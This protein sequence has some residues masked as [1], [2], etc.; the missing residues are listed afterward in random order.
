MDGIN[1]AEAQRVAQAAVEHLRSRRSQSLMVVAMN[2]QQKERIESH[3]ARLEAGNGGLGAILDESE[4]E[5]RIEP[6]VVKNL[7][8]VQG[9]E[10]DVVMISMTYGPRE[11]GG[12]VPQTFGPINQDKGHRRLNVLFTRAK[13]QMVVFTSLRSTDIQAGPESNP[14]PRALQGFLRFAETKQL[15]SGSRLTGKSPES[16]F[17]EAVARELERAGYGVEPQLGVGSYRIDIAVRNPDAPDQFLLGVE[18]DG[19]MYHTTLSAR[20]RDRLRQEVLENL[21]WEIERI[22]SVDWFRDPGRELKRVLDRLRELRQPPHPSTEGEAEERA[23]QV[24]DETAAL[25]GDA[26]RVSKE[27]PKPT[28]QM[29]GLPRELR[30]ALASARQSALLIPAKRALT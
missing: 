2:I 5:A 4:A 19:A 26:P 14:G 28:N 3:I 8:N 27:K 1:D 10:R 17:E 24:F 6:F 9:D 22:W 18:C 20:D 25:A 23:A 7:E 11:P 12:R 30:D 13:E 21:G 16:P 29:E 15:P